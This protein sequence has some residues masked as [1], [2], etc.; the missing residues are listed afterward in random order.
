MI[1]P[2]TT[3]LL[4]RLWYQMSF[5]RRR[6]FWILFALMLLA[7]VTEIFSIGAVVP[8]LSALS[9]PERAFASPLTQPVVQ[10]LGLLDSS[11]LLFSLTLIFALAVL[12]A[13]AVRVL[14]LWVTTRFSFA[15]GADIGIS[16]YKRTLYQPYSVHVARNTSEVI[17]SIS[18][19][20]NTVVFGVILAFLQLVSAAVILIIILAGLLMVEPITTMLV[21]GGFGMLYALII[22]LTKN[23][24]HKNSQAV[25]RES[26]HTIK[27]LQEGLG[28]IRDVLVDGS[29]ATYCEIY[30]NADKCL[31]RAQGSSVFI[32][33]C[34]RYV[35]EAVGMLLI[36]VFAYALTQQREDVAE[37]FPILGAMALGAQR[38]LPLLQQA[39]ASWSSIRSS[40]SSLG[41]VLS[42]LDQP[43]PENL[44]QL[45]NRGIAFKECIAFK[46]IS[47][48]YASQSPYVVKE[49]SLNITK[50]SRIG[51]IGATGSGKSTLLDIVMGLL[52]PTEGMLVVD[53]VPITLVNQ[54]AW[55]A[56]IA[57]VPQAIFMADTSIEENI[58]FGTPRHQIDKHRVRRAAQQACIAD[59]IESWA[60]T[61]QTI[62]GER[63]VRLSGGQRQRIG[64]A[65]ALYKQ[66]DVIIFDEATSALDSETEM[67]VMHA[68][69]SLS[70]DL[71]V[72]I[73]AHR[74][75]TLQNCD[76]IV[77][78]ENGHLY[79]IG[80][81]QELI[82][83]TSG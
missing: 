52:S 33:Q 75:T 51:F 73:I 59:T 31:R 77:K 79:Q 34:P 41:D 38:L 74:L 24:L 83:G 66:A 65:R 30:R 13:G 53:G 40:Q 69:D 57:H 32:A 37:V 28:G 45:S 81:Y 20:T 60:D 25:A 10:M 54:R 1:T 71:T 44:S 58:A 6:Q 12:V 16:I 17:T 72:L 4:A 80:T 56:N 22:K 3:S 63:G 35:M 70:S 19:K 36:S 46:N 55:Q 29:Q 2:S 61:Y 39:Y 67:A 27:A 23:S 18:S 68:I 42:L 48:R 62:V 26:T 78:L 82:N 11:Q 5:Q 43:M 47:F 15:I 50:G 64:I 49:V 76:Y 8:F 7:A 21:F 14:L 9:V